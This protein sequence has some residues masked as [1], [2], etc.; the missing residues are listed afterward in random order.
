MEDELRNDNRTVCATLET[1]KEWW[2]EFKQFK[3]F[4]W[5]EPWPIEETAFG[6]FQTVGHW[7]MFTKYY[8]TGHGSMFI[9]LIQV[10]VK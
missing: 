3:K 10:K 8:T 2:P 4:Y 1:F 7:G 6:K 9:G 5:E